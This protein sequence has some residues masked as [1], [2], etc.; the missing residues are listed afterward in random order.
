MY[1]VFYKQ[2]FA[3]IKNEIIQKVNMCVVVLPFKYH[4]YMGV[5]VCMKT[6][7]ACVCVKN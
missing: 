5:L 1:F 4:N 7:R 6:A 3:L 2:N